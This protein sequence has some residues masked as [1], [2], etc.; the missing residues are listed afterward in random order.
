[1]LIILYHLLNS[2]FNKKTTIWKL[3]NVIRK[4]GK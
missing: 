1:M 2:I 3:I 4:E